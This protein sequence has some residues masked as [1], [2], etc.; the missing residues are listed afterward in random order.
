MNYKETV[1]HTVWSEPD[2]QRRVMRLGTKTNGEVFDDLTQKLEAA[3]FMP[4]LL[5]QE[6]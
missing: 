2:E 4:I 5:C 6:S 3:G 1:Q